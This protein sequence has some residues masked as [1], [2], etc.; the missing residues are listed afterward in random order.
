[1]REEDIKDEGEATIEDRKRMIA[2]LDNLSF[3]SYL[4]GILRKLVGVDLLREQE[5]YYLPQPGQEDLV[6]AKARPDKSASI[7]LSS[8]TLGTDGMI[9]PT[10]SIRSPYSSRAPVSF[11]GSASTV[12]QPRNDDVYSDAYDSEGSDYDSEVDTTKL[13]ENVELQQ[14]SSQTPS[15]RPSKRGRK[16]L[17]PDVAEY[18]PG[19]NEGSDHTS[20]AEGSISRKPKRKR[21]LKRSRTMVEATDREEVSD[22]RQ[23]KKARTADGLQMSLSNQSIS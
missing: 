3:D 6:K 15:N 2:D 8:R 16:R 5:V 18:R 9:S 1:M 7:K 11:A 20:D 23:M 19:E 12:S 17:R 10:G 22:S 13:P 4:V 21:G 14:S